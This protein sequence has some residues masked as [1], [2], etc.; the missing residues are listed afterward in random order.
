MLTE[1]IVIK[2]SYEDIDK[3]RVEGNGGTPKKYMKVIRENMGAYNL[4]ED[5]V[6]NR[7][8][9]RRKMTLTMWDNG[10]DNEENYHCF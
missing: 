4:D 6:R 7:K 1:E 8:G 9:W 3:I 10:K 5:M 2:N